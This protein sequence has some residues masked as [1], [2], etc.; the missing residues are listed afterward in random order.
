MES[1]QRDILNIGKFLGINIITIG[2]QQRRERSNRRC[3]FAAVTSAFEA[4]HQSNAGEVIGHLPADVRDVFDAR[5]TRSAASQHESCNRNCQDGALEIQD[6]RV[7]SQMT[8]LLKK[9][10]DTC[11]TIDRQNGFA[12]SNKRG[13]HPR[14]A[15]SGT[16]P[17]PVIFKFSSV[18]TLLMTVLS[19]CTSSARHSPVSR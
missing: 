13:T 6:Y 7:P 19:A 2:G 10:S 16:A 9:T 17:F 1:D 11:L 3:K 8:C 12:K 18:N 14:F 4:G 5:S 15:V